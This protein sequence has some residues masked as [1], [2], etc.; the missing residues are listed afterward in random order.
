LPN[1]TLKVLRRFWSVHHNPVFLFPNRKGGLKGSGKATTPLDR[2]GVQTTIHKV[3]A[4]CG[5][6]KKYPHIRYATAMQPT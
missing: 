1:A 2:G 3:V 5:I 6:K 4:E